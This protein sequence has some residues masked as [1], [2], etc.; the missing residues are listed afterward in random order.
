PNR[1]GSEQEGQAKLGPNA[2]GVDTPD[3]SAND[4]PPRQ[5]T[6]EEP[7]G[8]VTA[9][10]DNKRD[11]TQV[12]VTPAAPSPAQDVQHAAD[13]SKPDIKKPDT[14]APPPVTVPSPSSVLPN[15]P[16]PPTTPTPPPLPS[17]PTVQPPPLGT[18]DQQ[19]GQGQAL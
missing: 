5:I 6:Y 18:R 7:V 2:P 17:T 3:P 15:V 11:Q 1:A 13:Q 8:P 4:A 16:P 12:A 9:A 19:R 10:N 14:P